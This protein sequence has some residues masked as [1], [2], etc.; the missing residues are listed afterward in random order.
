[1]GGNYVDR[2]E[3]LLKRFVVY[4]LAHNI[5]TN[6]HAQLRDF[7]QQLEEDA[8][9]AQTKATFALF[10]TYSKLLVKAIMW[11]RQKYSFDRVFAKAL[12]KYSTHCVSVSSKQDRRSYFDKEAN[13]ANLRFDYFDAITPDTFQRAYTLL[14]GDGPYDA[15]KLFD[16]KAIKAQR[17]VGKPKFVVACAL[18]HYCIYKQL[19]DS[20]KEY[21]VIFEDDAY[22]IYN[23]N[24]KLNMV[25]ST[26][27]SQHKHID[28]MYLGYRLVDKHL[29]LE[30]VVHPAHNETVYQTHAYVIHRDFAKKVLDTCFPISA[31]VDSFL[32]HM[33]QGKVT[34][35]RFKALLSAERL[36]YQDN[37]F[38]SDLR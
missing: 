3:D 8:Y 23:V 12:F 11:S 22:F 15:A 9:D 29:Q 28:I 33:F 10:L 17:G 13:F 6:F 16:L 4:C 32:N 38:V 24:T 18:S 20:D 27:V 36:V 25:M 35:K 26:A 31:A 2:F 30:R 34:D 21:A 7:E 5:T 37:R 1:M 14:F 19:I